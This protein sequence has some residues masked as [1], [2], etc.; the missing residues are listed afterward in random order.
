[1]S[2]YY[3][4]LAAFAFFGFIYWSGELDR[5]DR[6]APL[7][8]IP[9]T[10]IKNKDIIKKPLFGVGIIF[11]VAWLALYRNSIWT[12]IEVIASN[13]ITISVGSIAIVVLSLSMITLEKRNNGAKNSSVII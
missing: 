3:P 13:W 10:M 6:K 2:F 12:N 5:K 4:F 8:I 1:M 11:L 9:K 7:K